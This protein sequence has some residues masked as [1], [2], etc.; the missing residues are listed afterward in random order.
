MRAEV[1]EFAECIRTGKPPDIGGRFALRNLAVVLSAVRA[2]E[3]G[4]VVMVE[5]ALPPRR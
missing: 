3:S 2:A 1:A 5:D 4:A